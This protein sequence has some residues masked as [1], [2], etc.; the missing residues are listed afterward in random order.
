METVRWHLDEL[1]GSTL[2]L[3]LY[4]RTSGSIANGAGGDVMT[5]SGDGL[6]SA[7]VAESLTGWHK[8]YADRSSA[9]VATGWV[10]MSDASPVVDEAVIDLSSIPPSTVFGSTEDAD[11]TT[12]ITCKVG[13]IGVTKSVD[14]V[15]SDGDEIDLST[16]GALALY[17]E[18]RSGTLIQTCLTSDA[19]LTVSGSSNER[20]SFVPN[21]TVL[22]VPDSFVWALRKV[23]TAA[24]LGRKAIITGIITVGYAADE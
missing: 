10:N 12:S 15:D 6:F 20:F 1:S 9:P 3:R 4:P 8:A 13:E 14:C 11:T 21:A 17:I 5:E 23:A 18:N 7:T 19:T 22:A 24:P 16:Y 2:T